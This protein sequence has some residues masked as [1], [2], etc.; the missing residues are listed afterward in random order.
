VVAA[1]AGISFGTSPA[2]GSS[3]TNVATRAIRMPSFAVGMSNDGGGR[4]E[5][6]EAGG[7]LRAGLATC[8]VQSSAR[9]LS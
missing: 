2:S 1:A 7:L 3:A 9:H 5:R 6:G 8:I 4:L